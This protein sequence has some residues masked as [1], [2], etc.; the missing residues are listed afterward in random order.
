MIFLG[1]LGLLT[2]D[3][4][5]T[6]A[7]FQELLPYQSE[8]RYVADIS[9]LAAYLH[10]SSGNALRGRREI[11]RNVHMLPN[12]ADVWAL[13]ASYQATVLVQSDRPKGFDGLSVARCAEAALDA[14]RQSDDSAAEQ[15]GSFQPADLSQVIALISFGY[16]L[17]GNGPA[18]RTAAARAVHCNPH[19]AASWSVLLAAVEPSW[20]QPSSSSQQRISWLKKLIEHIRRYCDVTAYDRL[21]P[22]LNNYE[23]FLA[24]LSH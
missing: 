1:A 5:L 9:S 13:L 10:W 12:V 24:T 15:H 8:A 4:T 11:C 16:L 17:A 3:E 14:L 19:S 7:A 20:S 21:G 22:W 6:S 2:E 18:S 23:N